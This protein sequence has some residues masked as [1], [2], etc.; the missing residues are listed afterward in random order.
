M[1]EPYIGVTGIMT[2]QE[3]KELSR[4]FPK[5]SKRK[6]MIGVLASA[7]TVRGEKNRYPNRYPEISTIKDIF[8]N[9]SS[10]NLVHYHDKS[11]GFIDSLWSLYEK[12]KPNC[13]GFQLNIVWPDVD[14]LKNFASVIQNGL[15]IVLQIGQEALDVCGQRNFVYNITPYIEQGLI[16]GVLF[17]QGLGKGTPLQPAKFA[18]FIKQIMIRYPDILIGVAGGLGSPESLKT[19][20]PVLEIDPYLS[21]DAESQ[22][23]SPEDVLDIPLASNYLQKASEMLSRPFRKVE[24]PEGF[25]FTFD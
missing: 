12:S 18:P 11:V 25:K 16:H 23:R 20:A 13:H 7:K 6:L 4:I 17:D 1:L 5:N 19:L 2:P 21:I 10:V 24:T 22:I 3:A 14:E 9:D 8:Q 15:Q